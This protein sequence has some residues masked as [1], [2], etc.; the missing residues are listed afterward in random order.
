[1]V[2]KRTK[3]S[4]SRKRKLNR[5]SAAHDVYVEMNKTA[6]AAAPGAGDGAPPAWVGGMNTLLAQP[7]DGGRGW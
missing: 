7:S 3:K 1:M 6:S 4:E 2:E 5:M